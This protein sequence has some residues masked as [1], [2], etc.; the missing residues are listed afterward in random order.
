MI[1]VCHGEKKEGESK[2]RKDEYRTVDVMTRASREAAEAGE[3]ICALGPA[4][5]SRD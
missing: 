5:N 2:G 3:E 4:D 1:C